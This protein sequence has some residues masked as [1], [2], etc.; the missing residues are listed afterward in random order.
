MVVLSHEKVTTVHYYDITS[1][2]NNALQVIRLVTSKREVQLSHKLTKGR[3]EGT[4]KNR[5]PPVKGEGTTSNRIPPVKG[6]FFP[7]VTKRNGF[8]FRKMAR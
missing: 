7:F 8:F 3:C 6:S 4:T 5:I 2:Q 1:A